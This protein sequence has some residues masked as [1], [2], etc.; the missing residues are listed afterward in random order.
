[1]P[2]PSPLEFHVELTGEPSEP[3]ALVV[4]FPGH[5]VGFG[6]EDA[7]AIAKVLLDAAKKVR[8]AAREG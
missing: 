2:A 8:R 4:G 7:E 3:I 6:P 1:M 5:P